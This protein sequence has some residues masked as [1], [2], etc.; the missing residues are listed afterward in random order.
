MDGVELGDV[1]T[2]FHGGTAV[3]HRQL[4]GGEPLFA[5]LAILVRDLCGMFPSLEVPKVHRGAHIE[6]AEEVVDCLLVVVPIR[7]HHAGN[8]TPDGIARDGAVTH[9]PDDRPRINL[10]PRIPGSPDKTRRNHA[11]EQGPGEGLVVGSADRFD[12]P[13]W[14]VPSPCPTQVPSKE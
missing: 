9:G 8:G 10:V 3:K 5:I 12:R 11:V 14:V 2:E 7:A 13:S 6:V 1:H 4:G